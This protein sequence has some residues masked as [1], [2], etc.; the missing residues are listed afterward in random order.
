MAY[1]AHVLERESE[2]RVRKF[3]RVDSPAFRLA[4]KTYLFLKRA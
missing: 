1:L 4:K 2:R 3:I